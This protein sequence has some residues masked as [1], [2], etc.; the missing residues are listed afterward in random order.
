MWGQRFCTTKWF[1]RKKFNWY[2]INYLES[3]FG[4]TKQNLHYFAGDTYLSLKD[5]AHN[6][7]QVLEKMSALWDAIMGLEW[8][9]WLQIKVITKNPT[10][11]NIGSEKYVSNHDIMHHPFPNL[12]DYISTERKQYFK[13]T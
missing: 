7:M 1:N 11:I 12:K 10:R 8:T 2:P 3:K 9:L 13:S 4:N 6:S 5:E